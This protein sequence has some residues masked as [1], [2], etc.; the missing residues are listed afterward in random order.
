VLTPE[1]LSYMKDAQDEIYALRTRPITFIYKQ[2]QRDPISNVP[3]G[4]TESTREIDAVITEMSIKKANG[5]RFYEGGIEYEQGD[6]KIDV[7]IDLI[8]D[9][10]EDITQAKFNDVDYEILGVDKKGI[11]LRNRYELLGREIA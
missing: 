10:V 9:I 5:S 1:D 6:I 11:G 2:T 7:K 3:I 8:D 4:E